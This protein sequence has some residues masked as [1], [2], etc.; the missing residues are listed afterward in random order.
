MSTPDIR[1]RL[2]PEGVKEVLDALKTVQGQAERVARSGAGGFNLMRSAAAQLGDRVEFI[3]E[4]DARRRRREIKQRA[5]VFRRA[6]EERRDQAVEPRHIKLKAKLFRNVPRK[7][8]LAR[9]GRAVHQQAQRSRTRHVGLRVAFRDAQDLVDRVPLILREHHGRL[10]HRLEVHALDEREATVR[11]H[12][13]RFSEGSASRPKLVI[14]FCEHLPQP[15][16]R[17]RIAVLFELLGE[18]SRIVTNL[19][20]IETKCAVYDTN[21]LAHE[22]NVGRHETIMPSSE[23][24]IK[25]RKSKIAPPGTTTAAFSPSSNGRFARCC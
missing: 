14:A 17:R 18:E 13:Q 12:G 23:T 1:V 21:Q 16:G 15:V 3:E 7:A 9:A 10:G 20:Y 22:S 4:Q 25:A 8:A 24:T 11:I 6:A 5:D 2:S 19:V